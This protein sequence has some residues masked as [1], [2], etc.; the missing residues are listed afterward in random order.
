MLPAL[1]AELAKGGQFYS[2]GTYEQSMAFYLQRPTRLALFED[3]F[4]FGLEQQPQLGVADVK[5]LYADWRAHAAAGIT[6]VAIM[7]PQ[8]YANL[9]ADGWP[10][11]V[12]AADKRRIIVANR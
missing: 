12:V 6:D 10:M 8:V 9:K 5:T 11:R 4:A 2:V 3:E 1:R 7:A